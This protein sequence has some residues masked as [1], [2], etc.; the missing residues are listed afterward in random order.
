[1]YIQCLPEIK[2]MAH[3]ECYVTDTDHLLNKYGTVAEIA[4]S[5]VLLSAQPSARSWGTFLI[6]YLDV[7]ASSEGASIVTN[8]SKQDC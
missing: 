6:E 8:V 5:S 7:L 4:G 3:V 1:M 2:D